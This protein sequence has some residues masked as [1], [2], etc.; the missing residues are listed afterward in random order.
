MIDLIHFSDVAVAVCA[1][2]VFYH[3]LNRKA[4]SLPPGP[5]RLPLIG[6]LLGFPK[7]YTWISW[8][9][10]KDLYGPI[11]S[12]SILGQNY[13]I[14]NDQRSSIELLEKRSL[15]YSARP[16]RQ[17]V[18]LYVTSSLFTTLYLQNGCELT[19]I[20]SLSPQ[21]GLG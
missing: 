19:S 7:N 6:N 10:Y 20:P 11:S 5:T 3:F 18:T 15:N 16:I 21:G 12:I 8:T 14:L 1:L 13:I 9:K 2:Y 4:S 17:F